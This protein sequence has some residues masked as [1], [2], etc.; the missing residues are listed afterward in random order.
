ML[1]TYESG[2]PT[3]P[4][5]VFLHGAGLSGRM[6]QP[7]MERLPDYYCLAPDLPEQGKS[8]H[9][10]PFRLEDAAKQVAAL[11]DEKVPGKRAHLVG[12]SLGADLALAIMQ[13]AP[14]AV[15]HVVASAAAPL[16]KGMGKFIRALSTS[17]LSFIFLEQQFRLSAKMLG[18]PEA[19]RAMFCEDLL[20]AANPAFMGRS[21]EALMDLPQLLPRTAEAPTLVVVGG[22]ENALAKQGA[23]KVVASLKHAQ[24][25]VVP[26][27]NH[28]WNLQAPDLFTETVRAWIE[29]HPLPDAL[30]PLIKTKTT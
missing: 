18:I 24:G 14:A 30:Q 6:W 29:D 16:S 4:A 10:G 17:S 22:K 2:D 27:V 28:I 3:A 7:Q 5:I 11:I 19:Y 23:K 21:I 13:I 12:L 20:L 15:D 25:M 1:F 26:G 8:L 9:T